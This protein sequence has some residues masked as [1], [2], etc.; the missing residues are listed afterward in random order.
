[1]HGARAFPHLC[2]GGGDRYAG[3]PA[4]P[5]GV[6]PG[7]SDD[8]LMTQEAAPA[9]PAGD[10]DWQLLAPLLA[11]VVV[12]HTV[13]GILRVTMSYRTV[14]LGLPVIWLGVIAAGFA[15]VPIFVAVQIG[16]YIDRGHDA[17]AAW[18]GS[19]LMLLAAFGMWA[20]PLSI[21]HLL[22]FTMLLGTGH[23]FLMASQQMLTVR[24]AN[25]AGRDIAFG[26]FMVAISVGQGLGPFIVGQIGGGVTVPATG[27]LFFLGL[28]TAVLCLAVSFAIRPDRHHRAHH[29]NGNVITLRELLR[30]PGMFAIIA[31]S[32][33]T[34]TAGDLLVI[35]LPLLGT[36]RSIEAHHIGM[37]LLVRSLSALVARAFYARLIFMVGRLRLTLSSTFIASGAFV[38]LAVPSLPV[39]YAATVLIGVG[40]GIASTLTLSGIVE[41]APVEARGTAMTLRITGN[42][43]GL[44]CMPIV[45]GLVAAATGAAGILFLTALTLATSAV[46]L[47]RSQPRSR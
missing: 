27:P 33:V 43:I 29:E 42:R 37:L 11:H 15:L 35:Y 10:V 16:R 1:M 26:H 23:M 30:R 46:A 9:R 34:V 18:I 44:V 13:V 19:A 38:L 7:W 8:R 21:V 3:I 41:V 5:P 36:E 14:E 39:M 31:A 6:E 47:K 45:A 2:S 32:I 40:L 28:V 24:C 4:G 25:A 12:T 20:W 22:G 17:R